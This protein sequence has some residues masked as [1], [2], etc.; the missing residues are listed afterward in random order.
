MRVWLEANGIKVADLGGFY[1]L[2]TIGFG[3]QAKAKDTKEKLIDLINSSLS[4]NTSLPQGSS[5]DVA[6]AVV[7]DT[8]QLMLAFFVFLHSQT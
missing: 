5:C 4:V 1:V 2:L 3:T 8:G 6:R 7:G